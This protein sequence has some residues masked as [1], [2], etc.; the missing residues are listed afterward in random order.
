MSFGLL[1]DSTA[2]LIAT[3]MNYVWIGTIVLG[4]LILMIGV[5]MI[6]KRIKYRLQMRHNKKVL[7]EYANQPQ[8]QS[9]TEVK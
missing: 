3:I 2:N 4:V 6:I 5:I 1:C 9:K 8:N 7:K